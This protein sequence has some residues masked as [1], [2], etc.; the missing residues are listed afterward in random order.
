MKVYAKLKYS[1]P[2]VVNI[3]EHQYWIQKTTT[4][5]WKNKEKNNTDQQEIQEALAG[6]S[7]LLKDT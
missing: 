5:E 4:N 6:S 7:K 1:L 2:A 3:S